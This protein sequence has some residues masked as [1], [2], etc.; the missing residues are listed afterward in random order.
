MT[1]DTN[2]DYIWNDINSNTDSLQR[3]ISSLELKQQE[4]QNYIATIDTGIRQLENMINQ[5]QKQQ[6]PNFQRIQGLRIAVSKNVELITGLYTCYKEFENVK[7]RY[8]KE[9]ND[10]TFRG[11][12]L[13]ELE[14]SKLNQKV[15]QLDGEFF[16]VMKNLQLF[17]T[18]NK[19][20][21]LLP[22]NDEYEL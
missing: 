16:S 12:R 19:K 20:D 6:Q 15:D 11:H 10:N 4:L 13:I 18:E 17:A 5:E 8:Y 14:L 21:D 1:K 22:N 9:I 7:Q 3:Q 2:Y